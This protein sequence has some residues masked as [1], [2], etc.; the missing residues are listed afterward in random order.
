MSLTSCI[1]R[2]AIVHDRSAPQRHRF[3]YKL[4]MLYMDLD[5]LPKLF[6][7]RWLWSLGRRN[8]YSFFRSDYLGDPTRPLS[9]SVRDVVAE[10]LGERPDGPVRML[11]Q[12]RSFGFGFTPVTFYYCFAGDASLRAIVAEITNTPWGERHRYVMDVVDG[13]PTPFEFRKD[14]H[15]SP[16]TSMDVDYDWRFAPPAEQ[17]SIHMQSFRENQKFFDVQMHLQ[18]RP[19]TASELRRTA[20]RYPAMTLKV[21]AGIYW[22]ALRLRL[23]R[24]P[25]YNHPRLAEGK[26]T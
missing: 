23:K 17:L 20:L 25:F 2:G 7:G 10:H 16:F 3:R 15:I 1:Y 18:R 12:L 26:S 5:E 6:K 24:V 13:K 22:Q 14:F 4:Y 21:F 8:L 9:D 19:W 11:T